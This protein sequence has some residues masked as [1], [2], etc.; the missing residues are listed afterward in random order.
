MQFQYGRLANMTF[1][2]RT[3]MV[4]TLVAVSAFP[5]RGQEKKP[6]K[7]LGK[8]PIK[9]FI[10]AGQSNMVGYG[11][12]GTLDALAD[13]PAHASL[14]N[15][16]KNKDGSFVV[17]D[18]V[19]ISWNN[20]KGPLTVG[21]GGGP[22][23]IG[24]ELAFGIAMGDYFDEPV[25]LIKT[26]W[27]GTDLYCD[28]RRPSAGKPAYEIPGKREMGACYKKMVAE[29]HRCLDHLDADFPQ[30]KGRPRELC[31]FVWFQGWNERFAD[32]K[33]KSKVYEEYPR[34][35]V[36]LLQDVRAEFGMP[37]LPAVVGEM[38]VHGESP[39]DD[40]LALRAAQAK[41][42]LQ[43][44]LKGTVAF[45]RTA[46][47]WYPE[48]DSLE[49]KFNQ[50]YQRL[51]DKVEPEVKKAMEGKPAA[52]DRQALDRAMHQ[53]VARIAPGDQE[54]QKIKAEHDRHISH[55]VCHYQGSAR[56]Y[57]LIGNALGEAM[58]ELL[59]KD[60]KR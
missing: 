24:P 19:F 5:V 49:R 26:A 56:V 48:L 34:N 57:C 25:L 41:I 35:F 33:I 7:H 40:V 52:N 16:I 47:F 55:W 14:L 2:A 18:D 10:L 23:R 6:A 38:G 22:D 43:P 42:P 9:I 4:L 32:S 27:G 59:K 29:V 30:F 11:G 37:N 50:A 51:L 12:L 36:H 60:A 8:G 20:I 54:F 31:G 28:W 13:A 58:I 15:K 21:Q 45:V 39:G 17:R 44:E 1:L 53:A 46:C 3:I